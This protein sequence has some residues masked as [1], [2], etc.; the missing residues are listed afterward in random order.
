MFWRTKN[1]LTCTSVVLVLRRHQVARR[2]AR[3][4][5]RVDR[6]AVRVGRRDDLHVPRV[7]V[8]VELLHRG[9]RVLELLADRL[10]ELEAR[11]RRQP[12]GDVDEVLAALEPGQAVDRR[13]D[14]VDRELEVVAQRL[15]VRLGEALRLGRATS[16]RRSS[17]IASRSLA[18][19]VR[20]AARVELDVLEGADRARS[21]SLVNALADLERAVVGD[22]H[23]LG[24]RADRSAVTN[25]FKRLNIRLRF[26]GWMFRLST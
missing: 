7:H 21:A 16:R 12:L 22:D 6:H 10:V 25:S 3:R 9:R 4:V 15:G 2:Q 8:E 19:V 17:E 26:C 13:L 24:V 1:S 5:E 18:L 20:A 11:R 23:P 14:R